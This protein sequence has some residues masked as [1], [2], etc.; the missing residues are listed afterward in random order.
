M[1]PL[2]NKYIFHSFLY[3]LFT[4]VLLTAE[5]LPCTSYSVPNIYQKEKNK[6]AELI[7]H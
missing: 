1:I 5:I 2:L 7:I 4:V 3:I 6:T